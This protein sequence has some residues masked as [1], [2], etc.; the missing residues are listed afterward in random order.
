MGLATRG[1]F[2]DALRRF[3]RTRWARNLSLRMRRR[4]GAFA[5]QPH[6]CERRHHTLSQPSTTA[7]SLQ[8][9][10][11]TIMSLPHS[12]GSND[13]QRMQEALVSNLDI[14]SAHNLG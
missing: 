8:T 7:H 14:C 12:P 13:V 5:L 11:R 9:L 6:S 3:R 4:G 10:I 2:L 1:I